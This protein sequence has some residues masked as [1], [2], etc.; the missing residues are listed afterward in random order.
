MC[1]LNV[2]ARPLLGVGQALVD[3]S[4]ATAGDPTMPATR[5]QPTQ[6]PITGS[7]TPLSTR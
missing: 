3:A 6:R 1:V 7:A 5:R 2:F 4:R